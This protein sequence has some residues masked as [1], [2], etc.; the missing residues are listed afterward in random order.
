MKRIITALFFLVAVA[1]GKTALAQQLKFYYYPQANVYYDP[2]HK[3]Y[4]YYTGSAWTPVAVLPTGVVVTNAPRVVVY[5]STP[6][7]W[8]L[9]PQHVVKYKNYPNGKA[10]GYKGTNPNKAKGKSGQKSKGKN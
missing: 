6:A 10:T 5:S 1:F 8:K 4:I 7:V 9:N 2:A 3:Q